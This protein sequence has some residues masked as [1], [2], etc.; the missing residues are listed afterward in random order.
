MAPHRRG[1]F[2][3]ALLGITT[4]AA[5]L[6]PIR[7]AFLFVTVVGSSMEPTFSPGD[8]VIAIHRRRLTRPLRVGDV[9]VLRNQAADAQHLIKRI[10]ATGGMQVPGEPG[11]TVPT[12]SLWVLGDGLRSFDSRHFGAASDDDAVGLVLR[13]LWSDPRSG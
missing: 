7:T 8:R 5:V 12:G 4:V 1:V 9:V 6:R 2:A 3:A 11:Q 13:R 10:A